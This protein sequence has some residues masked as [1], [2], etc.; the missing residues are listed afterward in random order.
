MDLGVESIT[1]PHAVATAVLFFVAFVGALLQLYWS[2]NPRREGN[3][4]LLLIPLVLAALLFWPMAEIGTD[5]NNVVDAL[6]TMANYPSTVLDDLKAA[7]PLDKALCTSAFD[8]AKNSTENYDFPRLEAIEADF[9]LAMIGAGVLFILTSSLIFAKIKK[10]E[11]LTWWFAP[12]VWVWGTLFF[13]FVMATALVLKTSCHYVD[14]LFSDYPDTEYLFQETPNSHP[15]LAEL[16]KVRDTCV[17][18]SSPLYK[19]LEAGELAPQKEKV[20]TLCEDTIPF[21]YVAAA[22]YLLI[23]L[24]FVLFAAHKHFGGTGNH[25]GTFF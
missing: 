13:L 14:N 9:R 5:L 24:F 22:L 17:A 8:T 2:F 3:S 23:P 21:L 25:L 7:T 20:D 10:L 12:A 16:T 15:F 4:K 18:K 6:N 11:F 1:T 19:H